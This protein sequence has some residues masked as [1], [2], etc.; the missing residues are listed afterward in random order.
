[1][2]HLEIHRANDVF[3][4]LGLQSR[5][6]PP[7]AKLIKAS[8]KITFS[9]SVRPRIVSIRPP[10]IAIFDRESDSTIVNVWLKKR[11]F[12]ISRESNDDKANTG[13]AVA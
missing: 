9:T 1:M 3:G 8:F 7:S 6:I 10:N 11:G 4:A 5:R 12:I 13:L 2:Y